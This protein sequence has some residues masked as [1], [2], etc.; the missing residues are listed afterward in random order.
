M[1]Q[2]QVEGVVDFAAADL[3]DPR[4]WRHLGLMLDQLERRN[5]LDVQTASH[6]HCLAV[7]ISSAEDPKLQQQ[8]QERSQQLVKQRLGMLFP[9]LLEASSVDP[10]QAARAMAQTWRKVYGDPDDPKMAEKIRKTAEA[11]RRGT[12]QRRR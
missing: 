3:L 1:L 9:W 10:R 12:K 6:Q 2:A 5:L 4:W 11:L 8:L 7:Y